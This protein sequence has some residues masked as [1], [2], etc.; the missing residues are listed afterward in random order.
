MEIQKNNNHMDIL[1]MS[2]V[3]YDY[4][5]SEESTKYLI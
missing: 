2:T 4:S 3:K 5:D 1:F